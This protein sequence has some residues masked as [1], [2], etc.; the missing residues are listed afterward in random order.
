MVERSDKKIKAKSVKLSRFTN[1]KL[2]Y[3]Y[4]A[5]NGFKGIPESILSPKVC[6]V[7]GKP[8]KEF[9]SRNVYYLKCECGYIQRNFKKSPSLSIG[10]IIDLGLASLVYQ[11]RSK[12]GGVYN[13]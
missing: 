6:P 9:K 4:L 13:G 12:K 10:G 5:W 7:C 2:I 11:L 3:E 8:L 1:F